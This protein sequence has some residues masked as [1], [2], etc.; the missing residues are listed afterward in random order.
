MQTRGLIPETRTAWET[1]LD[2]AEAS[3]NLDYRLRALWGLWAGLQN[4]CE[5][6]PAL[7]LAE[8]F[9][10]LAADSANPM[11]I[12]V[13]DRM[14]G[15][16][17]HLMGDQAE[18]QTWLERMIGRYQ[19]PRVGAQMIRFVFD[20]RATAQCF[21]ARILWLKGHADRAAR[22]ATSLVEGSAA[23]NDALSLCQVLVQGAFPLALFVGDLAAAE[24]RAR[25]LLDQSARQGLEF[26]HAYGRGFEAVLEVRRGR[27]D[28]GLA[29]LGRVLTE[30]REIQFGV[31]Y[32][33]F[34][35]EQ[36]VA[37]GKAGRTP[38]GEGVIDE[39]LA[40]SRQNHELWYLPEL[41]RTKG[42]LVLQ[43]EDGAQAAPEAEGLFREALDCSRTQHALAWE[44]RSATSLAR[45]LRAK[46]S[47]AEAR[48]LLAPVH[49]GFR[50]GLETA[51][52]RA[53]GA[54]LQELP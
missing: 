53:A 37:L 6:R 30:L 54:L 49:A 25:M 5:L 42:E 8:R 9:C 3:G 24:R 39:A 32:G 48:A 27:L 17:L 31:L 35:C 38:E 22:L 23:G 29:M 36:A 41:L 4:R 7:A 1:V 28:T 16:I 47:P 45:L 19:P 20:Q 52:V 21:L 34:L 33:L 46:G 11:D 15:Y 26:W 10:A 44:L 40:R 51:D 18:A 13:G 50:E 43:R 12:H 2:L 14:V